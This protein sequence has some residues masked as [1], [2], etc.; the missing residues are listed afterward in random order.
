MLPLN[1]GKSQCFGLAFHTMV[2]SRVSDYTL[3]DTGHQICEQLRLN[4]YGK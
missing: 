2:T 1:S 3:P 4:I